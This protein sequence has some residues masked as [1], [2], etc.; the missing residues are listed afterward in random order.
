[1]SGRN[2]EP[3]A[4]LSALGPKTAT[5]WGGQGGGGECCSRRK[6]GHSVTGV[7]MALSCVAAPAP[8]P[9]NRSPLPPFLGEGFYARQCAL[10]I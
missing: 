3:S 8:L 6:A 1:M 2:W 4:G 10:E 7:R 5:P 9:E